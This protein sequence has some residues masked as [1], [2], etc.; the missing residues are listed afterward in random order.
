MQANELVREEETEREKRNKE[1]GEEKKGVGGGRK[2]LGKAH[3][4][5]D[6]L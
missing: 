1:R 4:H 6:R 5:S 2:S 3:F